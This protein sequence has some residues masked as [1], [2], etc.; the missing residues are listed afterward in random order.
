MCSR[1]CWDFAASVKEF[2]AEILSPDPTVAAFAVR[3][4]SDSRPGTSYEVAL[5]VD[6]KETT[7]RYGDV[8]DAPTG[9]LSWSCECESFCLGGTTCNHLSKAIHLH[10]LMGRMKRYQAERAAS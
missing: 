2:K 3:L 10:T 8:I 5:L 1:E 7:D 4:P 6:E 9:N